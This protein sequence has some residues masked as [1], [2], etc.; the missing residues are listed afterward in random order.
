[1]KKN[2]VINSAQQLLNSVSVNLNTVAKNESN[3]KA[4]LLKSNEQIPCCDWWP[5][6]HGLQPNSSD[7]LVLS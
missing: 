1:M 5:S 6:F 3:E 4:H 7:K 2:F